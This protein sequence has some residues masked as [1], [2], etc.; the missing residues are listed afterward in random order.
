MGG[1]R[2][3]SDRWTTGMGQTVSGVHPP[4]LCAGENCAIHR[5]SRHSMNSFPTH[6]RSDRG[7]VERICPHG[8]GHPD[9]DDIAYKATLGVDITLH[10]CDG[11]C[12]G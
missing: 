3:L 12:A 10:G 7:I 9:P 8:V 6:W 4:M 11:C 5:P 1:V 2:E